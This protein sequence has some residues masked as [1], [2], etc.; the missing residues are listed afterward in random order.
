MLRRTISDENNFAVNRVSFALPAGYYIFG[1]DGFVKIAVRLTPH[2]NR[3]FRTALYAVVMNIRM[4]RDVVCAADDYANDCVMEL[5]VSETI[6]VE[7]FLA[8]VLNTG[9]LQYSSTHQCLAVKWSV[10][11]ALVLPE[12]R[13]VIYLVSKDRMLANFASADKIDFAFALS[14]EQQ[15]LYDDYLEAK[16]S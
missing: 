13:V 16:Q 14:P 2:H 1:L 12:D 4:I 9:Y 3:R 6:R 7:Q 8:H 15:K 5:D 11:L 10:P